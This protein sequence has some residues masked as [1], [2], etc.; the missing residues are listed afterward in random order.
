MK[1]WGLQW[2]DGSL[3]SVSCGLFGWREGRWL[4]LGHAQEAM[5]PLGGVSTAKEGT[6]VGSLKWGGRAPLLGGV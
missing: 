5:A 6:E 2:E 1:G 4:R 3:G